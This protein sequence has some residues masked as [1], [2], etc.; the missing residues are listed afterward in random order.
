MM[1]NVDLFGTDCFKEKFKLPQ[2]FDLIQ[3]MGCSTSKGGGGLQEWAFLDI[4][5]NI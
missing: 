3:S 2:N 1:F 4:D 5:G